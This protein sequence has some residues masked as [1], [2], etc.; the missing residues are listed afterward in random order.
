MFS[1]RGR[2]KF[3]VLAVGQR[4]RV[5]LCVGITCEHQQ[6]ISLAIKQLKGPSET[7]RVGTYLEWYIIELKFT[8]EEGTNEQVISLGQMLCPKEINGQTDG[9]SLGTNTESEYLLRRLN[10]G[11]IT[12]Q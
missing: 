11:T 5:H 4:R 1:R 9:Q 10:V 12:S 8:H 2:I 3:G 6:I 7:I